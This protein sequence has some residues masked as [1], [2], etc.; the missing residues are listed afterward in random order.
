MVRSLRSVALPLAVVACCLGASI[1]VL[2]RPGASVY[3]RTLPPVVVLGTLAYIALE[4]REPISE[5]P[6]LPRSVSVTLPSVV[7]LGSA[8]LLVSGVLAGGRDTG[9]HL[10]SVLLGSLVLLQVTFVRERDLSVPVLLSQVLALAI[11]VRLTVLLTTPG[12]VGLDT[13]SH[14]PTYVS[15]ILA[16]GSLET[17]EGNKYYFAPLYHLLIV[18]TA[19]AG[20]LPVRLAAVLSVG[21]VVP[22]ATTLLTYLLGR[23]LLTV[24]WATFAASAFALSGPAVLWGIYPVPTSMGLVLAL[25]LFVSLLR[26][27]QVGYRFEELT[28]F[29]TLFGALVLTHQ[30]SSA[31]AATIVAAAVLAQLSL[32]LSRLIARSR[33]R[34]VNVL[35][36]FV[37]FVVVLLAVWTVTP[38]T[39]TE[40]SFLDRSLLFLRETLGTEAGWLTPAIELRDPEADYAL[41]PPED[42]TYYV[43][44]VGLLA[45]SLLGVLGAFVALGRRA[46]AP[47]SVIFAAGALGTVAVVTPA[48]GLE[49]FLPSRWIAFLLA[50][51]SVL[52]AAGLAWLRPRLSPAPA[53]VLFVALCLVLPGA[54]V[55]S[56]PGTV[57]DPT[58]EERVVFSF[59]ESELAAVETL[60][61]RTSTRLG[62]DFLYAEVF[63]RTGSAPSDIAAPEGAD[64]EVILYRD[65]AA[66][67]PALYDDVGADIYATTLVEDSYCA[68]RSVAYDSG[69]V[70]ACVA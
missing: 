65:A 13:W 21:L 14:M 38:F 16:E 32:V 68:E 3:V 62:T 7:L 70:R 8:A 56:T 55:L 50:P 5:V 35:P 18:A 51:L 66:E 54:M 49:N 15:G 60:G 42:W 19:L 1:A 43:E 12:Y 37:P 9:F 6:R 34:P 28:L 30:V 61:E 44:G 39:G 58:F 53:L 59:S 10:A 11:A 22:V 33:P 45:L 52:A 17:L 20:D 36:L 24:R 26:I 47:L 48:L 67:R 27:V 46:H 57:E 31:V 63:G 41:R 2:G 29:A 69:S 4:G 25:A 64:Q 40:L 23:T